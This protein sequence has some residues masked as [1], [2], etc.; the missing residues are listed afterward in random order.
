MD[1]ASA[2]VYQHVV[3]N[4][5][6]RAVRGLSFYLILYLSSNAHSPV[7]E[8][9]WSERIAMVVKR[10]REGREGEKDRWALADQRRPH[11]HILDRGP[12]RLMLLLVVRIY[13]ALLSRQAET[14]RQHNRKVKNE[15]HMPRFRNENDP[16][17]RKEERG[18]KS[19]SKERVKLTPPTDGIQRRRKDSKKLFNHIVW[20]YRIMSV[21][22]SCM[23]LTDG[24]DG[25]ATPQSEIDEIKPFM[26]P[27]PD[28][29][30]LL[31]LS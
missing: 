9:M 20:W 15:Q 27:D 22:V 23:S 30:V 3:C 28:C 7:H 1:A 17:H 12:R 2:R 4:Y 11:V 18:R 31:L 29:E 8:V 25:P 24:G 16:L 21:A 14:N 26:H 10:E 13:A 6:A 19:G 5:A